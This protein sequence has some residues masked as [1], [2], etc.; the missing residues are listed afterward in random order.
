MQLPKNY[1]SEPFPN[2]AAAE[3]LSFRFWAAAT[4]FAVAVFLGWAT[5]IS[6][7]YFGG[8]NVEYVGSGFDGSRIVK[9]ADGMVKV[10]GSN[11]AAETQNY[12]LTEYADGTIKKVVSGD[13]FNATTVYKPTTIYLEGSKNYRSSATIDFSLNIPYILCKNPKTPK[14]EDILKDMGSG[15]EIEK[16]PSDEQPHTIILFSCMAIFALTAVLLTLSVIFL[17]LFL[18]SA[19]GAVAGFMPYSPAMALLIFIAAY[20]LMSISTKF[21]FDGYLLNLNILLW[22]AG[23]FILFK[24]G[25]RVC[26]AFAAALAAKRLEPFRPSTLAAA[27]AAYT[28][29]AVETLATNDAWNI[30]AL[31]DLA[32]FVLIIF[33]AVRLKNMAK[34]IYLS[35]TPLCPKQ[36]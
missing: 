30:R 26:T 9:S 25:K 23:A 21:W 22:A 20:I 17:M 13:G 34:A 33:F 7:I 5:I 19:F 35:P 4:C 36:L 3:K 15:D 28:L 1:L 6:I 31:A 8:M 27:V 32:G 18:Y 11:G 29:F 16:S 10:S 24:L 12:K 2:P 14:F